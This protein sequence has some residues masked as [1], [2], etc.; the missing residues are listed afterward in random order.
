MLINSSRLTTWPLQSTAN[1]FVNRRLAYGPSQ[2]VCA[3]QRHLRHW[4]LLQLYTSIFLAGRFAFDRMP[5]ATFA[6][7]SLAAC[8]VVSNTTYAVVL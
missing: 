2:S 3:N 5:A 7:A 8:C 6:A 4:K 1:K